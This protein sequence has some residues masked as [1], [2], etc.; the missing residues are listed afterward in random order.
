M[1]FSV[2]YAQKRFVIGIDVKLF[3]NEIKSAFEN[4]PTDGKTLEFDNGVIF[5]GRT[6]ESWA[7]WNKSAITVEV[8]LKDDKSYASSRSIC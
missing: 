6:Q 5:L 3:S 7:T 8:G 4:S 1:F 2:E